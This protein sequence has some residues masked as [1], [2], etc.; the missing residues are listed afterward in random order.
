MSTFQSAAAK[1]GNEIRQDFAPVDISLQHLRDLAQISKDMD[2]SRILQNI[3]I[4]A[5]NLRQIMIHTDSNGLK[6]PGEIGVTLN[7]YQR[8]VYQLSSNIPR[9]TGSRDLSGEEQEI[10]LEVVR[11]AEQG[12]MRLPLQI[13]L[14]ISPL[15]LLIPVQLHT[16]R[17]SQA[18][19]VLV[20][21][22]KFHIISL[23]FLTYM[24]DSHALGNT[25][26]PL[27]ILIEKA[28]MVML[29]R[30]ASGE[31]RVKAGIRDLVFELPWADIN[32]LGDNE[33]V[34][35]WFKPCGYIIVE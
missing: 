27:L 13:A 34:N 35:T 19:I 2:R 12:G 20:S 10:V 17:Y 15:A 28:I 8:Y 7:K 30:I 31:V 22:P 9:L 32:R 5:M 18:N 23:H 14:F 25:K 24:K 29:F 11:S 21:E 1:I 16:T 4:A 33:D 3:L 6:G 26:P